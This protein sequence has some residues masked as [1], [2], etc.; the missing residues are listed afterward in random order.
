VEVKETEEIG[1]GKRAGDRRGPQPRLA[2]W[3]HKVAWWLRTRLL[4]GKQQPL[5]THRSL[6]RGR[7]NGVRRC[8]GRVA[9][10]ERGGRCLDLDAVGLPQRADR[11]AARDHNA[12]GL[13]EGRDDAGMR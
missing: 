3:P 11:A 4:L 13:G 6:M 5:S 10:C 8:D 9:T 7:G 2:S 1:L 12:A